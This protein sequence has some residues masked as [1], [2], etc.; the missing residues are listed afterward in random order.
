MKGNRHGFPRPC[1]CLGG[2]ETNQLPIHP[3]HAWHCVR[4]GSSEGE[5]PVLRG[6]GPQGGGQGDGVREREKG[7]GSREG[8]Q[9]GRE[10]GG[11]GGERASL[12]ISRERVCTK[13]AHQ[14]A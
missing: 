1:P 2:H 13:R 11:E 12:I 5:V 3:E 8:P 14:K 9:G 6:R 7:R 10:G 4:R